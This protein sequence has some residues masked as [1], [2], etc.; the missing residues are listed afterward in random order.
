MSYKTTRPNAPWHI[1]TH[2]N[3]SKVIG[4]VWGWNDPTNEKLDKTVITS[5][6]KPGYKILGLSPL[7]HQ[8]LKY[9]MRITEDSNWNKLEGSNHLFWVFHTLL[10]TYHIIAYYFPFSWFFPETH[11]L[12]I[13]SKSYISVQIMK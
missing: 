6:P 11:I 7:H 8:V 1:I 2:H 3:G 12:G 10:K 4:G 9:E 5:L 13:S